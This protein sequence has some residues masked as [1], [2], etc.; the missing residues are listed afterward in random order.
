MSKIELLLFKKYA[1]DGRLKYLGKT[2]INE[3]F[4]FWDNCKREL[5]K[6]LKGKTHNVGKFFVVARWDNQQEIWIY[7]NGIRYVPDEMFD[8]FLLDTIDKLRSFK[9]SEK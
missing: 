4:D 9:V 6:I 2:K 1:L 5:K 7:K 3:G 8:K